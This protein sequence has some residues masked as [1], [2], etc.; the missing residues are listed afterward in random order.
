MT[1]SGVLKM[2]QDMLSNNLQVCYKYLNE[3]GRSFALV[4]PVLDEELRH[5]MCIFYLVLRALD[6]VEDDMTISLERK[7]HMLQN[8]HSYLYQSDWKF[9]GSKGKDKQLLEDFPTISLEFRKLPKVYRD[10]IANTCHKSGQGLAEF[11]QKKMDSV[12]D[13]EKY[14]HYASGLVGIGFFQLFSASNLEDP[15][16]GQD[17]E[18]TKSMGLFLQKTNII[19]DYLEDQLEGR[20]FWPKEVWSKYARKLSDLGKP[21]NVDKAV[22]CMNE[23]IINALQH[24][25]DILTFLSQLKTQ[26]VFNF[27]ALPQVMAIATLS[28]CYNN[29][30]VFKGAVKIQKG[31]AVM[32]MRDATNIQAVRAIMYQYLEEIYRKIPV[33]DPSSSKIQEIV[34]FIQ[35]MSKPSSS[36]IP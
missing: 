7:V 11:L 23:L 10:V 15:I 4:I 2:D 28:A 27:C 29:Q 22:Q 9:M 19:R 13:W 3:T 24:I 8:F 20:E 16:V 34:P 14:C 32:L 1:G 26:S 12:K 21:E 31:Q 33:T 17:T 36:F 5:V 25:P 35:S 18:L 30:Q 6:T